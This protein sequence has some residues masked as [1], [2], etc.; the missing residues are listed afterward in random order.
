MKLPVK[1]R[2]TVPWISPAE[3]PAVK[4]ML[5]AWRK[6]RKDNGE[7]SFLRKYVGMFDS[8][9]E[10]LI[11]TQASLVARAMAK[12]TIAEEKVNGSRGKGSKGSKNKTAGK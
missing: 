10:R 5:S 2:D 1:D 8:D 7:I 9:L 11:D 6:L 12:I 4:I 3:I